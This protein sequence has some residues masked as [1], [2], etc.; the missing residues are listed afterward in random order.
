MRVFIL[1]SGEPSPSIARRSNGWIESL[2]QHVD[3]WM[4]DETST[5]VLA[6]RRPRIDRA[7]VIPARPGTS[8]RR[9][10]R[11]T[12][13]AGIA[14]SGSVTT[15]VPV[16]SQAEHGGLTNVF[17]QLDVSVTVVTSNP[18]QRAS[19]SPFAAGALPGLSMRKM[20]ISASS[21]VT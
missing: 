7:Y 8:P 3:A 1:W 12:P 5:A 20:I 11:A 6:R 17:D 4:S 16:S 2:V 19:P 10:R 9:P 21:S 18:M 14:R 13:K 15:S